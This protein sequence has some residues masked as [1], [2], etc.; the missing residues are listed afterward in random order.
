MMRLKE[1]T[2]INYDRK[3]RRFDRLRRWYCGQFGHTFSESGLT[4]CDRCGRVTWA[5]GY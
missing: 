3:W 1:Q 2:E 4:S 5:G